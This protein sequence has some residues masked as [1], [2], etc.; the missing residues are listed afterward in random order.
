MFGM[1]TFHSVCQ[2]LA[3]SMRAASSMSSGMDCSPAM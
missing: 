1:V 2:L 3:P